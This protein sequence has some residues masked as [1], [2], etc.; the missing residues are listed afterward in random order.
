MGKVRAKEPTKG[1]MPR[2]VPTEEDRALIKLLI[3]NGC[4]QH[5]VCQYISNRRGSHISESTLKRAFAHELAVAK[6]ELETVV[7]TQFMAA[8]MRGERWAICKYMDQRMW[9]PEDGGWRAR[10]YEAAL[11]GAQSADSGGSDLPPFQLIVQFISAH[12]NKQLIGPPES[13]L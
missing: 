1:G 3:A 4:P 12:S 6:V 9:R 7:L 2:F 11:G 8:I 13:A 10:R 5:K